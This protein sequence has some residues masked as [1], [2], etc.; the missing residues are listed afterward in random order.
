MYLIMTE[1]VYRT[2]LNVTV[3]D[4]RLTAHGYLI[5]GEVSQ[6]DARKRKNKRM[7]E[8]HTDEKQKQTF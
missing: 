2:M 1:C 7:K 5:S 8:Q 4:T 3:S 6:L